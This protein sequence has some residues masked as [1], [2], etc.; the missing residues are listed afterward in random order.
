MTD[1]TPPAKRKIGR[2]AKYSPGLAEAICKAIAAG[3]S[4]REACAANGISWTVVYG[5][6]DKRPEFAKLFAEAQL[7]R[8]ECWAEELL[9]IADNS[10]GDVLEYE[11]SDGHVRP[12][13]NN[14]AVQRDRLRSDNR[15]WLMG[16]QNPQKYGNTDRLELTGAGGGPIL[17]AAIATAAVDALQADRAYYAMKDAQ[18]VDNAPDADGHRKLTRSPTPTAR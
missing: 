15:K 7:A 3:Q 8:T 5:W 1:A 12:M 18:A 4:V 6:V 14:A 11:G 9:E 10:G 17:L 13:P 2:P 16:K